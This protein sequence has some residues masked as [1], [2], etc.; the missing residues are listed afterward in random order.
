MLYYLFTPYSVTSIQA[1]PGGPVNIL[2]LTHVLN[3]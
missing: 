1:S 3:Y 2:Y